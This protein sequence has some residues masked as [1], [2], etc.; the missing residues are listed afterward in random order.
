MLPR[1]PANSNVIAASFSPMKTWIPVPGFPISVKNCSLGWE[2][3]LK[4]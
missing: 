2:R 1:L 3:E 4:R